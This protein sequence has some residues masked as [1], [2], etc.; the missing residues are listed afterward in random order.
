MEKMGGQRLAVIPYPTPTSMDRL[1]PQ[2]NA[3]PWES[4]A[5]E[6][7]RIQAYQLKGDVATLPEL[8]D[9]LAWLWKQ[10]AIGPTF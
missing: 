8:Q 6:V 3:T 4:V 1:I 2:S 10:P 7:K 9:Y 5:G